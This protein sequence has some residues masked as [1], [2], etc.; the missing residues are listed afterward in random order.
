MQIVSEMY[1]TDGMIPNS[2]YLL[3]I[4]QDGT[5]IFNWYDKDFRIEYENPCLVRYHNGMKI[6]YGKP[7][8]LGVRAFM[9]LLDYNS[10]QLT[11]RWEKIK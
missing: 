6:E 9:E 2:K 1:V 4:M 7:N 5:V 8:E 11:S 3:M 10:G